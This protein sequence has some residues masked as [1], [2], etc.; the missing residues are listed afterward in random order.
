MNNLFTNTTVLLTEEFVKSCSKETLQSKLTK[1]RLVT[2]IQFSK[3]NKSYA[4]TGSWDQVDAAFEILTHWQTC[5]EHEPD[6]EN[7]LDGKITKLCNCDIVNDFFQKCRQQH[8]QTESES[9]INTTAK[10]HINSNYNEADN[11]LIEQTVEVLAKEYANLKDK[12]KFRRKD[13]KRI[14]RK[15]EKITQDHR[16]LK[17]KILNKHKKEVEQ[18]NFIN[19]SKKTDENTIQLDESR[20]HKK[21]KATVLDSDDFLSATAGV[22]HSTEKSPSSSSENFEPIV[23]AKSISLKTEKF[24]K[25]ESENHRHESYKAT[26]C[27]V[28]N[29]KKVQLAAKKTTK[30][31]KKPGDKGYWSRAKR[32]DGNLSHHCQECNV[33]L[34][35]RKR[36]LEHRRRIHI[37]EYQCKVC[38][39]RFGY[40][41]DLNR[42][43]C[44]GVVVKERNIVKEYK[45]KPTAPSESVE[46]Q[47]L[48]CNYVTPVKMRLS[49]HIQ[50][51][52]RKEFA[53]DECDRRFG[54]SKDLLKHKQ[55]IHSGTEFFCDQCSKI[56]KNK[57]MFDSH[58]K[59]HEMGYVKPIYN[60]EH[61]S[62]S[63]TTKYSLA[64]HMKSV[65]LGMKKVYLCQMCGKKFSQRSSYKQHCNAHNGIK[66]YKCDV[67]E[68]AFVYHKSLKEH[69]F[70]HDNIRRFPCTF[71]DKAFRQRTTLH[72]HLKTHKTVKD[73]VCPVCGRG[74]AQKQAMERHERI[75][76][77]VRPYTCLVCNKSFG[78][79]STI[80]RHMISLH[81]KTE[82]NWREEILSTV[83][84]KSDYY[85]YGGTG[86]NRVYKSDPSRKPPPSK[87]K[88]AS[89]SHSKPLQAQ[90]PVLQ[91]QPEL[92]QPEPSL[93]VLNPVQNNMI[94][95]PKF[96]YVNVINGI[97]GQSQNGNAANA[98]QNVQT[99][100]TLQPG[101]IY[102]ISTS[103]AQQIP[104]QNQNCAVASPIQVNN[105]LSQVIDFSTM[106]FVASKLPNQ[107][108]DKYE[109]GEQNIQMPLQLQGQNNVIQNATIVPLTPVTECLKVGQTG[110]P[111]PV[112]SDSSLSQAI[113]SIWGFVGYPSYQSPGN[114]S[115]YQPSQ[116]Q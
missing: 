79:T 58:L 39:K 56:Y 88:T 23:P 42:H 99:F 1:L 77:G 80:R 66:P 48:E 14:G 36:Y 69:K 7:A 71:C 70:M 17:C 40:P 74:F 44:P 108:N 3:A 11:A 89:V 81:Q 34:K 102:A 83:K 4:V 10:N 43:K 111:A 28:N 84:K 107:S 22:R 24:S 16:P 104:Q 67:C 63:L 52:H 68:K 101:T 15:D 62:K 12:L 21:T 82:T 35:S 33:T 93:I 59:T 5:P 94:Q 105:G 31:Q 75:H 32:N 103:Q 90:T 73:H 26:E 25:S 115:Q 110:S 49:C 116:N 9:R 65:H 91:V 13:L 50:R 87:K 18:N 38:E 95:D 30:K 113:A 109:N 37:R 106:T 64:V 20:L 98:A 86:Q 78:D 114:L 46:F 100:Q 41:T 61:C 72:I 19:S 29:D 47:C 112:S 54:Y 2:G 85:V 53:C 60:C 45:T 57:Q 55:N 51:T 27:I 92:V 8:G 76:S 6:F 97:Q 96:D